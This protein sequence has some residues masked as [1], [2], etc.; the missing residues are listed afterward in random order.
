P[1]WDEAIEEMEE[2]HWHGGESVAWYHHLTGDRTP[3]YAFPGWGFDTFQ[4]AIQSEVGDILYSYAMEDADDPDGVLSEEV[5]E[6]LHGEGLADGIANTL[7][8][9][10]P[11]C[12]E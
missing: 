12:A 6:L 7:L 4:N 1:E 11:P 5:S 10:R 3:L 8:G 9:A 2:A